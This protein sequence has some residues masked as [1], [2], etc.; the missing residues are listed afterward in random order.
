[1]ERRFHRLRSTRISSQ[2]IAVWIV[3][4]I[5]LSWRYGEDMKPLSFVVGVPA[6]FLRHGVQMGLTKAEPSVKGHT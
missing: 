6:L 5:P 4:W 3:R 1:M 2:Q